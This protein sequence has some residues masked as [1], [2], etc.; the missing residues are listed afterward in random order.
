MYIHK[1]VLFLTLIK[2]FKGRI[3]LLISVLFPVYMFFLHAPFEMYL[4]NRLDFWFGLS[5]FWWLIAITFVAAFILLFLIGAF[6]PKKLRNIYSVIGVACGLCLYI[7]GNF[8]NTDLGSLNGSEIVWSDYTLKFVLNAVIWVAIIAV[9]LVLF[10]FLK[11]KTIKVFSLLATF[12]LLIQVV[13]LGTLLIGGINDEMNS[14]ETAQ[15][16]VTDRNLYTVSKDENVIIMI[17][18]MFDNEYMREIISTTPEVKETFKDFTFFDNAVGSYSTTAYAVGTILTGEVVGNTEYGLKENV[19]KAYENTQLFNE[20]AENNYVFDMYTI[21]G[22][23]PQKVLEMSENY[24]SAKSVISNNLSFIK[25]MYRLVVCRFAPDF[26][27]QRFWLNG[28]EFAELRAIQN[29]EHQP[30]SDDTYKFYQGVQDNGVDLS[31]E[32]RFKV[33]HLN[34]VH[35]PYLIDENANPIT[36]TSDKSQAI[37]TAKGT[38]KVVDAY[39]DAIKEQGAWDNSTIILLADHGYYDPGVL[40]N[41]LIMVKKANTSC[42]FTVSNAPVSHYDIHA[43][44]MDSLNLNTNEKYGKSMFN[45]EEGEQRDRIFYQYN[46]NESHEAFKFRLVEWTVDSEGNAR[47][48]FK[49]TGKEIKID[50]TVVNHFE[51]C[52]YCI[53]NGTEPVDAPNSASILH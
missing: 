51:S 11:E 41:P 47:K 38:L 7:Q 42:D 23:T 13:T 27:K 31:D 37:G 4:T 50:S 17:L 49:L 16:T 18:D 32:K 6:L 39:L 26:L 40:T 19:D 36:A 1:K 22:M 33:I 21:E 44:I 29:P 35:F 53:K 48:Y 12:V 14:S 3:F 30:F 20:L 34:A 8:L 52:E 24:E 25:R 28:T 2:F 5:D 45:I 15:H 43:T 46:L 10:L 9:A